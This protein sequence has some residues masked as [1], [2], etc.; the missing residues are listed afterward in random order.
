MKFGRPSLSGAMNTSLYSP[1]IARRSLSACSGHSTDE[2][3]NV[4]GTPRAVS[5]ST[6]SFISAMSGETTRVNPPST[7]AG[8][9]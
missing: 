6:W 8:T 2:L 1:A 5:R 3:M 4:A 9:Q 7:T